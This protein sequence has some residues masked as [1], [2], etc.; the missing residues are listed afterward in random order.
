MGEPLSSQHVMVQILLK[1]VCSGSIEG[2][3]EGGHALRG[4]LAGLQLACSKDSK[5]GNASSSRQ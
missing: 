2:L 5:S 1:A 4:R 3:V